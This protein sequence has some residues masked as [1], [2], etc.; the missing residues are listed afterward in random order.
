MTGAVV[1]L[2]EFFANVHKILGSIACTTIRKKMILTLED[3]NF[4][5]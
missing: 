4:K 3:Y 5:V 2:V 1:L